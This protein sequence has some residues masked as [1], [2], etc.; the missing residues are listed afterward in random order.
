[1]GREGVD[2]ARLSARTK[3]RACPEPLRRR[4]ELGVD[5]AGA[6]MQRSISPDRG[7]ET[8]PRQ[9]GSFNECDRSSVAQDHKR[10]V[11]KKVHIVVN[12]LPWATNS[13]FRLDQPSPQMLI[14]VEEQTIL[15]AHNVRP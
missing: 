12:A 1:M 15:P 13:V 9:G 11:V 4:K 6:G 10:R 7:G 2:A 8:G 5:G 14:A 3:R